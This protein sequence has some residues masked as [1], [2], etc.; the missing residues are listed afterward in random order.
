MI[1]LGLE[2]LAINS[3]TYTEGQKN[4]RDLWEE[5]R[6]GVTMVL[7]SPE[8]LASRGFFQLLEDPKFTKRASALGID[9]LHLIY[10]GERISAHHFGSLEMFELGCLYY[11]TVNI[12][13]VFPSD[14]SDECMV[15]WQEAPGS[16]I[17]FLCSSRSVCFRLVRRGII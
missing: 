10:C 11:R 5:V 14:S 12:L 16:I 3:G 7:L 9:E 15:S 6:E 13:R 17:H 2:S 4:G 1:K 8:Q